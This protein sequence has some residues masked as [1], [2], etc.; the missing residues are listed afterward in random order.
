MDICVSV[1]VV[2]YTVVQ[3]LFTVED[4]CHIFESHFF[5]ISAHFFS[6]SWLI[7]AGDIGIVT[8]IHVICREMDRE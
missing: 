6:S 7:N 4:A 2:T 1:T 5:F 3:L 8:Q